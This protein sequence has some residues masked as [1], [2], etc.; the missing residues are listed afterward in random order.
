MSHN[1]TA[2]HGQQGKY[3]GTFA[4]DGSPAAWLGCWEC[5]ETGSARVQ[6][7]RLA[8]G[9]FALR[10]TLEDPEPRKEGNPPSKE[11]IE[12]LFDLLEGVALESELASAY[13]Y[14]IEYTEG[15][16]GDSREGRLLVGL[17]YGILK[18]RCKIEYAQARQETPR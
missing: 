11:E 4:Y 13:N 1:C 14:L 16:I 18:S 5:D 17:S 15:L 9:K 3:L 7:E 10:F 6:Q 12:A 2:C 8:S